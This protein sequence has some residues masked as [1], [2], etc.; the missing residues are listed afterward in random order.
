MSEIL[1]TLTLLH[2]PG[3]VFELRA[4]RSKQ[5][6]RNV[7]GYFSDQ[8]EAARVAA[9]LSGA[10]DGVYVT[11]NPVDPALLA[12]CANRIQQAEK[13][14]STTDNLIRHRRWL[15][16]D[17]D[18]DRPK[19]ISATDAQKAEA[20]EVALQI[21]QGLTGWPAPIFADSGNGYH[22]L[23]R[24]DLGNTDTSR[25]TCEAAIKGL[26]VRFGT[27]S[28]KIDT[29]VYNASRISKLYGTMAAKGDSTEDRPHR[30]SA[31]IEVPDQIWP[32]ATGLL[33]ALR[34]VTQVAVPSP[35]NKTLVVT[36]RSAAPFSLDS[37]L[38]AHG[39]QERRTFEKQG[40]NWTELVSCPFNADHGSTGEVTVM[41]F[42]SGAVSFKCHHASCSDKGWSEFRT[43]YEPDAYSRRNEATPAKPKARDSKD[44]SMTF[45]WERIPEAMRELDRFHVGDKSRFV[46]TGIASL[47]RR[48]GGGLRRGQA[49]L[50]AAPTGAGKTTILTS[51]SAAAA[52]KNV[53]V[54]ISPEMSVDELAEREVV[55]RSLTSKWSRSPWKPAPSRDMAAE[56]HAAAANEIINRK[57]RLLVYDEPAVTMDQ[58]EDFV[59]RAKEVHGDIAL[60]AI[61]YAQEVA[62]SDPR[63][64]R[65]LTVGAVAQRSVEMARRLDCAFLIASQVNV[66]RDAKGSTLSI[67]E[68]QILE[69]KSHNVLHFI[70]DWQEDP[71]AGERF[72][73]S[74]EFRATKCRSGPLFRLPVDYK[75]E[76]YWLGDAEA[77]PGVE[78]L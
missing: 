40:V 1:R 55:R 28:V 42:P 46:S 39:V 6:G 76:C 48:M 58:I 41:Q 17:C 9:K 10:Y 38:K 34:P 31:L 54:L 30:M 14:G 59:T 64:P 69:H 68:S 18:P 27:A 75:P 37:W 2:E 4:L 5:N 11:L 20:R 49:T 23:Y 56:K 70:V 19:G 62:D 47:D 32:V 60:V 51:M 72:V 16:V 52:Q 29:S 43:H 25:D 65:Y 61:D 36:D 24:I 78:S 8:Q 12:R 33:T 45:L 26:A 50:L 66:V 21:R 57:A 71:A 74:A 67:R 53:V 77:P 7:S 44:A 13:D 22:L 35:Q 3:A 73:K 15:L 63:T